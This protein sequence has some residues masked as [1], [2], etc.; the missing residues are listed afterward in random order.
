[1][2]LA[3]L[4]EPGVEKA[5]NGFA[6][7]RSLASAIARE[8]SDLRKFPGAKAIFLHADG[9]PLKEG[10]RLVQTD[11]AHTYRQ[12]AADG[13]EWFYRGKL[14]QEVGDWMAAHGGLVTAADFAAYRAKTPRTGRN[15][16]PRL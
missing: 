1:M 15:D 10:E 4:L 11:L 8:A 7:R 9:S 12:I 14:A 6:I 3:Q 5:A 16:L 13:P 2:K